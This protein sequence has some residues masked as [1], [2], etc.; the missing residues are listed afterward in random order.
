MPSIS[1][2]T[3]DLPQTFDVLV[4]SSGPEIFLELPFYLTTPIQTCYLK[5]ILWIHSE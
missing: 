3:A 5:K 4:V 2:S 1:M